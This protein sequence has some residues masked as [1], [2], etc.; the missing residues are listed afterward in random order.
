M[1]GVL[2]LSVG[3]SNTGVDADSYSEKWC[4]YVVRKAGGRIVYGC[5]A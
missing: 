4:S 3:G 1:A 5:P 2:V